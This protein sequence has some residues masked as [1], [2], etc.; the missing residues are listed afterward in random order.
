MEQRTELLETACKLVRELTDA[1]VVN[2][3]QLATVL[4]MAYQTGYS[5]GVYQT[6]Y[7]QMHNDES[8]KS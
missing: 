2:S 7:N 8:A 1:D 4:N 5:D 3:L 6:A